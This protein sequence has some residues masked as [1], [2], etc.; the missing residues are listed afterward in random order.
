MGTAPRA[1]S[2]RRADPFPSSAPALPLARGHAAEELG[3]D[4]KDEQRQRHAGNSDPHAA[5]A[6]AAPAPLR[7][8]TVYLPAEGLVR[9]EN[10][11]INQSARLH[12][13]HNVLRKSYRRS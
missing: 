6:G 3:P 7:N 8:R 1:R 13:R 5:S 12:R 10:F 11:A 2:R 9:A 4:A